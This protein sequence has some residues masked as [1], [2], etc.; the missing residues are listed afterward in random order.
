MKKKI[1][2]NEKNEVDYGLFWCYNSVTLVDARAR[3]AFF[4]IGTPKEMTCEAS[5][6]LTEVLAAGS[7][8]PPPKKKQMNQKEGNA[9]C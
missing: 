9:K 6:S 3:R 8:M 5:D 4:T 2:I 1:L 7:T